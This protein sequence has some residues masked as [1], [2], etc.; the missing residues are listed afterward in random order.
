LNL[1][2]TNPMHLPPSPET[3]DDLELGLDNEGDLKHPQQSHLNHESELSSSTLLQ[4]P[5]HEAEYFREYAIHEPLLGNALRERGKRDSDEGSL[6]DSYL[7]Q[8]K[9]PNHGHGSSPVTHIN[10]P[11]YYLMDPPSKDL[12]SCKWSQHSFHGAEFP[13]EYAVHEPLPRH[14]LHEGR[15]LQDW[16]DGSF[17]DFHLHQK[18]PPD[19]D[20]GSPPVTHVNDPLYYLMD[21]PSQ[22]GQELHENTMTSPP[23]NWDD[24]TSDLYPHRKTPACAPI[25]HANEAHSGLHSRSATNPENSPSPIARETAPAPRPTDHSTYRDFAGYTL[26]PKIFPATKKWKASFPAKLYSIISD[27][28]N[29]EA[30][31]WQPHGRCKPAI[32]I[33][34]LLPI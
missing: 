5:V 14:A 19:H 15:I 26:D 34:V 21:L 29:S 13:R 1:H 4:P 18:K 27:P 10:D 25:I 12:S 31:Q 22:S 16:D 9:P 32:C 23:I 8:K 33:C 11:L 7:H 28:A 6:N 3:L 2:L 17:A 30:I 24:D 20:A